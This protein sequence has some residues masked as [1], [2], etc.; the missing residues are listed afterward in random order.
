MRKQRRETVKL[1]LGGSAHLMVLDVTCD[2]CGRAKLRVR[3]LNHL[4][5]ES[6]RAGWRCTKRYG[7]K[8]RDL[9]PACAAQAGPPPDKQ[10]TLF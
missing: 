9:C 8:D 2:D 1:G 6:A 5:E 7:P 3:S 10:T 4:E